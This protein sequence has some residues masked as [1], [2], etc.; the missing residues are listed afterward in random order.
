MSKIDT[1]ISELQAIASN[2]KKAMDDYKAETGKGAVGMIPV[3]TPEELVYAAGRLPI[4]CWG[5]QTE[6]TKAR[7][8]LP[9]FACS[10]MQSIM[11]LECNGTYDGLEAVVF[12]APCDTLKCMG[13]KWK[14]NCP[15]IQF[16]HPQ[17]VIVEG[18][19]AFL[20]K[21]YAIVKEKLEGIFGE[22]ITDE[23]IEKAIAVY[24]EN[25]AVMREFCEVA[26]EYPQVV[27][28]IKRHAVIKARFFMDKAKHTAMVKELIAEL[29]ATPV[30]PWDGKKVVLT[31]IMA[32]PNEL[33]EVL[34]S[35]K[36][37]VVADDLA[38]ESR[39]FR[40]DVPAEGGD[41][42]TR[43]AMQ[44]TKNMYGCS[45]L[46]DRDKDRTQMLVNMVK[47]TGADAVI[48]CMM[49]FCDPEEFDYPIYFAKL[50]EEGIKN[51]KIEI[52]Q[53]ATSFEQAGT[54]IQALVETL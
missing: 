44:W 10:I 37:A 26:A 13:Q 3:Y 24:N 53:Q 42:L 47:K 45:L 30:Q 50:N 16:V 18:S 20:A 49:K 25:R 34:I 19:T 12:S 43:L 27:D 2:P 9:A 7:A 40:A 5:A 23:A 8:Y 35:N 32:E 14:G 48:V 21:E 28:P 38:Q 31:G 17:N 11:E 22:K 54:R 51:L 36:V 52:E 1:I 6:I 46:T 15:S 39:Q 29:K 41:V 4:G 33:L